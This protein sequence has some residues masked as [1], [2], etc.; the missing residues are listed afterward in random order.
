MLELNDAQIKQLADFSSNLS[1]IF[2]AATVIAPVFAGAEDTNLL[3]IILGL[4]LSAAFLI[5]SMWILKEKKYE[6]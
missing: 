6:R 2:I 1:L 4:A 5:L 3:A